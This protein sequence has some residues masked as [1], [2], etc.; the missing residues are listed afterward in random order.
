M[1]PLLKLRP[2]VRAADEVPH[3]Y[4]Y[5]K[6]RGRSKMKVLRNILANLGLLLRHGLGK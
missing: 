4:R 2:F 3:L 5:G 6:K 1:D